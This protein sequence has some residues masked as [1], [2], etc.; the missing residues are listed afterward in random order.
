MASLFKPSNDG[1]IRWRYSPGLERFVAMKQPSKTG[2]HAERR[3]FGRRKTFKPAFI[4]WN[5]TETLECIVTNQSES[6]ALLAFRDDPN[7]PEQF[8]LIINEEDKLVACRVA[9]QSTNNLG[10]QFLSLPRRA[11]R[12]NRQS[13]H[14]S[15]AVSVIARN[16]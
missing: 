9:Y 2:S 11:S 16:Y 5:E 8:D 3:A 12:P 14:L 1:D 10:V 15:E 13:D 7:A 4:R 6:G